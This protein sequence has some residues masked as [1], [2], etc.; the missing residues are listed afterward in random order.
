[1]S[2]LW[3]YLHQHFQFHPEQRSAV[4]VVEELPSSATAAARRQQ[5]REKCTTGEFNGEFFMVEEGTEGI[6]SLNDHLI[7]S[8]LFCSLVP[9]I[10]HFVSPPPL[11]QSR[12]ASKAKFKCSP[13]ECSLNQPHIHPL[14]A[15]DRAAE[16]DLPNDNEITLY[17]SVGWLAVGL[18][19]CLPV[20]RLLNLHPP[21]VCDLSALCCFPSTIMNGMLRVRASL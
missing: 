12:I 7:V 11:I 10:D 6:L 9:L 16:T 5:M 20:V 19:F 14:A 4:V 17:F 1:M 8:L 3:P 13:Q 2:F 15:R 18:S 21:G